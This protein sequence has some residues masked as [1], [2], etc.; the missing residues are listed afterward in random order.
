MKCICGGQFYTFFRSHW[1]A[2][3]AG[4]VFLELGPRLPNTKI[5]KYSK[6]TNVKSITNKE[7]E[8]KMKCYPLCGYLTV[9]FQPPFLRLGAKRMQQWKK[10]LIGY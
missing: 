3:W 7:I 9:A 10:I 6:L 8:V 5:T 2:K 1:Q 4:K